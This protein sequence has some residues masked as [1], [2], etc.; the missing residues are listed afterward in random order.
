M[1]S[2]AVGAGTALEDGDGPGWSEVVSDED[3]EEQGIGMVGCA[4]ASNCRTCANPPVANRRESQLLS[5][6]FTPCILQGCKI[7]L[8]E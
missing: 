4:F 7:L 6:E 5:D 2:W 3:R 1:L 8:G